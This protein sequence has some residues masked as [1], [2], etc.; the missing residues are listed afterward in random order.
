MDMEFSGILGKELSR[1]WS[2]YFCGITVVK[3][4]VVEDAIGRETGFAGFKLGNNI[5]VMITEYFVHQKVAELWKRVE[6][7]AG[8]A[9]IFCY[10]DE[11]SRKDIQI[12][13]I[14]YC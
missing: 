13:G 8:F 4:L 1:R 10:K 2:N 9:I 5:H 11:K 14:L 6:N 3:V 12:K 7:W